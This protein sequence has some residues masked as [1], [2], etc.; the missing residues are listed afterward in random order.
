MLVRLIIATVVLVL[1][2]GLS[3]EEQSMSGAESAMTQQAAS[4]WR[5]RRLAAG[6]EVYEQACASCHDKGEDGAPAIGNQDDWA[7]RSPLWSAVLFGHSRAGYFE[8]PAR[9]TQPDLTDQQVDAASEYLLS[10]TY[11]ELPLD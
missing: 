4:T 8:M 7:D 5:D 9:G 10:E 3:A 2:Q 6:K 11:P 1:S